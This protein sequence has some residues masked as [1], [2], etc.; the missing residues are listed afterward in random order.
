[1]LTYKIFKDSVQALKFE[2]DGAGAGDQADGVVNCRDIAT[3][4]SSIQRGYDEA[5]NVGDLYRAWQ[6][7]CHVY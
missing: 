4:V 3:T 2:K 6:R 1:M 7:H 5:I